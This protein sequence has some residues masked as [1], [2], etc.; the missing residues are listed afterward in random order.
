[1]N[2]QENDFE[3]YTTLFLSYYS[4]VDQVAYEKKKRF[5]SRLFKN[6][7]VFD[8][9]KRQ[10]ADLDTDSADFPNWNEKRAQQFY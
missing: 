4:D 5:L 6:M 7:C 8:S 2:K 1:M 3:F 10:N 9:P